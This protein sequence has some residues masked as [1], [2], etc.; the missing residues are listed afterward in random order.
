MRL[1][2]V[3]VSGFKSFADTVTFHFDQPKVG[4]VGPNGCGK[5]NVVDAVK[6]VLGER[7]AKSLRGGAMMDVIF[8]GSAGRKP[9]GMA[10]VTLNFENP[11]VDKTAT[12]AAGRRALAVDTDEVA[13]G[14]RLYRDGRSEYLINDRKVRLKDVKD[15]FLDT[16][17]G[18]AA[19]C[20]IEQ[21]RVAAMLQASPIERRTILEEAAGVAKFKLRRVESQRK[22]E[23]T[24]VNL[25][26]VREQLEGTERRLRLVRGQAKKARTFH[27]LDTRYRELRHDL[28]FDQFDE[29]RERLIGLTSRLADLGE[30]QIELHEL[31]TSLESAQQEANIHR[32]D[33]REACRELERNESQHQSD[34]DRSKQ[35]LDFATRQRDDAAEQIQAD[36]EML[37]TIEQRSA[38]LGDDLLRFTTEVETIGAQLAEAESSISSLTD[39]M[40]ASSR[41]V[42]AVSL[43]LREARRNR[44]D[45]AERHAAAKSDHSATAERVRSI[46]EQLERIEPRV[47]EVSEDWDKSH[48]RQQSHQDSLA[49][50]RETVEVAEGDLRRHDDDA[51][52]LGQRHDTIAD[53]LADVRHERAGAGSRLHLLVEMEQAQEGLADDVKKAL[54]ESGEHILGVLG[55]AIHTSRQWATI[56]EAVLG[57]DVELVITPDEAA[58]SRL[59][60]W[61][62]GQGLGLVI[63]ISGQTNASRTPLPPGLDGVQHILDLVDIRDDA[64]SIAVRLLGRTAVVPTFEQAT[65]LSKASMRDW[66]LVAE[67]GEVIEPDGRIRIGRPAA[68]GLISRRMEMEDLEALVCEHDI[69]I[70]GLER[71]LAS[72]RDASNAADERRREAADA[73]QQ[74]SN[75]VVDLEYGLQGISNELTRLQHQRSEIED[76]RRDLQVRQATLSGQLATL[77]AEADHQTEAL[78]SLESGIESLELHAEQA[79]ETQDGAQESLSAARVATASLAEQHQASQRERRHVETAAEA[80]ADRARATREHIGRRTA[81]LDQHAATIATATSS[82]AS[83]RTAIDGVAMAMQT[84][85]TAAQ[86]AD[87]QVARACEDLS[88]AQSRGKILERDHHALELSRRE[89]EVKRESLEDR[90]LEELSIDLQAEYPA[91]KETASEHELDRETAKTEVAELKKQ[92]KALGNVNIDAIEEEKHLESR[93]EGLI[94]QVA[95]IDRARM[96]LESLIGEL[97]VASRS[98]FEETFIA[99][100]EHFAGPSGLFRQLF[101]GG[102]ADLFLVPDEDGHVDMLESGIEIKAKPPGKEP[103]VISQLSGGEKTMAAVALLLAIFKSRPAPFCILDE[104]DAALD[105]ANVSRF[106]GTIEQFLDRSH[107]IIIT[108]NKQTMLTCDRLYGVT[109]PERGVSKRVTVRVDEVGED[110]RISKAA[111]ERA[112]EES[113]SD[114]EDIAMGGELPVVES[115]RAV[116]TTSTN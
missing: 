63:A 52:D 71:D 25:V 108:H 32:D 88:A 55:E 34:A 113:T 97:E 47:S 60:D 68:A 112:V 6:W 104:V 11:I 65:H 17:I 74:A 15:I 14:R 64:R 44:D 116:T 72:L 8:A 20:I 101:G 61:A 87:A 23:R 96:Q 29:L 12:I 78:A 115:P 79:R 31:A 85:K 111:T 19:Y 38:E 30:Q 22:L 3:T 100:R 9:L 98:R 82:L 83:A 81:Q 53:A 107:F 37:A 105:D 2:N 41:E 84:S 40:S 70:A 103:R 59:A 67:T 24:D 109:Q 28:V 18:N 51:T 5:S 110:G 77:A 54:A 39:T 93:N 91:W 99:V 7:S 45:V 58:A 1:S 35:Q 90:T 4:I 10:S 42:E 86:T 49:R 13:V 26:R 50:I 92:I 102:S 16:G 114:T 73:L 106:C 36:R 75:Q 80:E 33:A 57:H 62:R 27:E 46:D 43:K 56:A 94:E 89:G 48:A 95:D 66:R 21:G 69:R 76:E